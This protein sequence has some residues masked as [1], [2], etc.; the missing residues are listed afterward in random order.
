MRVFIVMLCL[1]CVSLLNAQ[2]TDN[3]SDGD[4]TANPTWTLGSV[5]D[6]SV[7]A[8]QLKSANT[9]TNSSFYISTTNTLT[10]NCTWEFWVNLQF[11]TS[12]SNYVDAYLISDNANLLASNINGYFVRIG[13]TSDDISLYKSTAGTQTVI[14]DGVNAS[15]ASSSN[16]LIKVKVTR[17]SANLFTLERDMTGTG[18]SYFTEGTITDASFSSSTAF[19]FVI[20]QSTATFFGKHIFDDINVGTIVLDLTPPSIVSNTVISN[21]QLDV[22]FNEPLEITSAQTLSNYSVNN[23]ISN[24]NSATRDAGNLA[25]V[26]LSF[27]TPFTNS[28][29][30][31]LTVSGVKDI[32]LNSISTET[33]SF[34][35][36]APITV[37]YKDI[38]VNEIYADPSPLVNL[39]ATE[40]VELYNRSS[41]S[42]NLNGL[43]LTDGS[44]T[45]TLGNYTLSPNSYVIVCPIADTA[46]FTALGY[47]NKLGV[48]SFPSLNNTSDN[49][50]LKTT[51][52][53]FIDSVNYSDTWYQDAVKKNGGWTLEQINPNP[54]LNCLQA[55]NWIASNDNDGGTP[56]FVN[57]VYSI[58]PDITGP[59]ILSATAVDATH[60]TVCFNEAIDLSMLTNNTNYSI[61]NSIGSPSLTTAGSG[62]MCATLSLTN[63]LTSNNTYTI[64]ISGITDC[65]GNAIATPTA[66]FNFIVFDTPTF[67]DVIINEI[68]VDINPVPNGLP[69]KQYLEFYNKSNKYFNLNGWKFSDGATTSTISTNYSLNPNSYVLIAKSTDTSGFV[70]VTNKIGTSSFPTF[71]ISG[72]PVFIY[73]NSGIIID[74]IRY[75]TTWYKNTTKD[76]GGWSLELINPLINTSCLDANNWA[77][78]NDA[79]G[80]TPGVVNS[81]YSLTPDIIAPKI[82]SVTVL[83]S[84]HISVCF[85][86]A[87]AASQ[88]SIASNYTI[89]GSIGSP[90]LAAATA[91][92]M[93]VTLSLSSKLINATNYTI[94][95]SGI[96]DCSGNILSPNTKAFSF[97]NA[98]P[99]DI[100]I[101]ELMPDPDPSISLPNEEYV[102][103]KNRTNFSINL[104][105][106][107]FSSLTT[108]KKLPDIT[109]APN[110]YVV[111][112]GSGVANQY[113]SNFGIVVYEVASFPSLLNDGTTVTLRDTN[114]VVIS[115]VSYSSSWYNDP[116]K[117]DGGWSIEQIDANNP[118]QGQ[119]NWRASTHPNGG[120]PAYP[121]SVAATNPDNSSPTIDRVIVLAADTIA[122]LFTEPLDSVT[123]S[124]P[125]NYT[126]DN[127]LTTPTYVKAIA[128]QF[129]KVILKLSSPIQLGTIYNVTV[130]NGITDC[131]GNALI[132]GSLPFALPEAPVANDVVI[133]EIL[134]DP[135]TGGVDFVELYNR[136]SKTINLKDLRLGS[137]DTLT[138]TLKDTEIL[139]EEGYLLFPESYVAI[140]ESGASVKQQ[141]LTPNPKGFLDV[142]DLP[143]MNTDDDVVTLSDANFTV[144][145]NFKYTTKMHFPL[146]VTTKGVSL[147]RIDFNRP[148]NDKTNWNSAAEAVGFA[149]PAYRNSQYLQA[150]GGSGVTIPNPLF[151]P[152]NDGYNDVLNISYKLD[153]PGKAANVY[154]YD[155]KGR[156]VRHLIRN[157]QLAQDGTLSWNGINDDNEKAP[158]GIYV[159]YVELFNLSGKVN[160]Y[161]LSCTLA[162]KL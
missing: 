67:N 33:T 51:V 92:N 105:N 74:S 44:S 161:K 78:S 109:I 125:L 49:L 99:Y 136:S 60:I 22:L 153:E 157:E 13:N 37:S 70:G 15:V 35:Y 80:G 120:T 28:L 154:I 18:A 17:T 155:S 46:Q 98:K 118:C 159:V 93:C 50:Y 116:N 156:Q 146:L 110:G 77:A 75:T 55:I 150:D 61:N 158:I 148:T 39:T 59:S 69:A 58:A 30:N 73:D 66:S 143:S 5:T 142:V 4:F 38:I 114:N 134:F 21:T 47:M 23:A 57:S 97:Y 147:E 104:K 84:L 27:T 83:D 90:T 141:Y 89:N 26:H 137:M 11:A 145:D 126:F 135:N 81:I 52:G 64:T 42:F 8:G 32:A 122:L 10:S 128:P 94:T 9:T 20:K 41:N 149:T 43:K 82:N 62:N 127:S 19:G 31:T 85:D 132:N 56:G 25:L 72:D 76:D 138:S 133:N 100:V 111:L 24:P 7:G 6:F 53:L 3:F 119:N 65:N 139:T 152:D 102:E 87:I 54:N 96:T 140:S 68:M 131:V 71:N 1:F 34:T 117:S 86:D 91:D 160:K 124:N 40:F 121:N 129:K 101:N 36:T 12:G 79:N 45:A 112:V 162:G 144:I 103:L 14:I 29:T 113:L 48:S 107:S 88:L 123:L 95:I 2:I 151:S 130:L 108:S 63:S 115:S 16:N 106:W